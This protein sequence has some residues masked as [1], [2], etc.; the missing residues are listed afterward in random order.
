MQGLTSI[1]VVA[2]QPSHDLFA[3]TL[4]A[5]GGDITSKSFPVCNLETVSIGEPNRPIAAVIL[6]IQPELRRNNVAW[7]AGVSLR[8]EVA[9]VEAAI[10]TENIQEAQEPTEAGGRELR[11]GG[12]TNELD[13]DVKI[14]RHESL[15]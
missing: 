4:P 9:E 8:M 15:D 1:D 7:A 13:R 3:G 12:A 14:A 10:R 5:K 6:K 11:L 2:F